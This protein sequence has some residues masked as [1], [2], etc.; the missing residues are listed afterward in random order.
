MDE[1]KQA[2][3]KIKPML[4]EISQGTGA[5]SRDPIQHAENCIEHMKELA[6]KA[7]KIIEEA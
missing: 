2:L 6:K 4:E 7:L 3:E 1:Y 5:Y